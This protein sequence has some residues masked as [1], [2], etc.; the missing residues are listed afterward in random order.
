MASKKCAILLGLIA[1]IMSSISVS[2]QTGATYDWRDSSLI[3]SNRMPQHNEFLN[4]Q[5]NFPAKPRNQWEVGIKGGIFGIAGDVPAVLP[6]FAFGAHVRK[7]FGYVFSGRIEY[8][9]GTGKGLSWS[10]AENYLHNTAWTSNGYNPAV[11]NAAGVLTPQQTGFITTTKQA[12]MTLACKALS[13]LTTSGFTKP[14][15]PSVS[16]ALLAWV[17]PGIVLR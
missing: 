5:Y 6:T 15:T 2:A 13:I 8:M 11:R 17:L 4:N 7:A 3:P 16:T 10:P 1:L 14:K 12:L 9:H